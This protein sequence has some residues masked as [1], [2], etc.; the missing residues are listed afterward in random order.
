MTTFARSIVGAGALCVSLVF[1]AGPAGAQTGKVE[2]EL[3]QLE[4]DWC[5]ASVKNDAALLGGIVADDVSDISRAG[6]LSGKAEMLAGV[7][8]G[9]TSAC[10]V[11]QMKVRVYG[12]AAV[13]TG[14]STLTSSTF[15]G[16][17]LWTDTFVK[18]NGKW[19]CVATQSTEVAPPKK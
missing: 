15:S 3:M 7:K 5:T 1:G 14:R 6:K 17:A 12:D 13:V 4:R 11:D 9:K 18:K 2:Q 8:T 10:E 19:L 16:Q